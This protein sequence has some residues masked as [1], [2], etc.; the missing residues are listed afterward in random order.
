[1]YIQFSHE[2]AS[3]LFNGLDT[4]AQI[5]GNL[6]VLVT[7]AHKLQDLLFPLREGVP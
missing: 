4:D 2:V 6:F 3:V 1:M 5:I 7:L